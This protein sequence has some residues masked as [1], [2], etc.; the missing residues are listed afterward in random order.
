MDLTNLKRQHTEIYND[1]EQINNLINDNNFEDNI[2]DFVSRLNRFA[3]K[4]QVHLNSEDKFLYPHLLEDERYSRKAQTYI[5]EMGNLIDEFI[6]YKNKYNTRSRV[7]SN[8]LTIKAET[9]KIMSKVR[10]RINKEDN[11]LYK[12]I[13]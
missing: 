10:D 9:N 3:G 7:E 5:D 8:K 2:A 1:L 11:D 13:L 6:Q 12:I 4:I